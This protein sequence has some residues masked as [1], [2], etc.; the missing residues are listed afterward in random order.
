[1]AAVTLPG[2]RRLVSLRLSSAAS[3]GGVCLAAVGG[4]DT[5]VSGR[6]HHPRL[7]I[8]YC[9]SAGNI[10][11]LVGGAAAAARAASSG[12]KWAWR[13]REARPRPGGVLS[14]QLITASAGVAARRD[15]LW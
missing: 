5:G 10:I 8:G 2:H 12:R 1:M 13:G 6:R 7:G 11:S 3:G 15:R 14:G 9:G 4:Y